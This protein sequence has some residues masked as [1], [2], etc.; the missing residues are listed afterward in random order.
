M[1]ARRREGAKRRE[2]ETPLEASRRRHAERRTLIYGPLPS[3]ERC[4]ELLEV[5]M[6]R[7]L[8][9]RDWARACIRNSAHPEGAES[10]TPLVFAT[11]PDLDP[12]NGETR[13]HFRNFIDP[14][15]PSRPKRRR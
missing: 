1:V 2:E 3:R 8:Q 7:T 13:Q 11:Y 10:W 15:P 12:T 5:Y 9:E 4:V 14:L 6:Y